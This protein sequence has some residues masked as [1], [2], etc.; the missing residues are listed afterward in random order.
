MAEMK[1]GR[2]VL[3][4]LRAEGVEY[5]FGV[6]GLTTNSMVTETFGRED[7]RF[8]DTRH[9][10]GAGLMA[11]GYARATGRPVACMTTSGPG[12]INLVTSMS[13]AYK[14]RAPVLGVE[15]RKEARQGHREP[16]PPGF[17][18][19]HNLRGTCLTKPPGGSP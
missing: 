19:S 13:L 12:T 16:I 17:A 11:Y 18:L 5:I 14:G 1:A 10:E 9:E 6:T 8:I 4:L 2:A 7:I 15:Q 3:E